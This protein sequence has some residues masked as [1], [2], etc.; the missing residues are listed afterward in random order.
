[1]IEADGWDCILVIGAI[2]NG[3]YK[4]G[5]AGILKTHNCDLEL[6]TEKLAL[7]PIENFINKSHHFSIYINYF[8]SE[9]FLLKN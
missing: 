7:D 6:L 9:G 3:F 4:G 5:L 1:M 2:S 8:P